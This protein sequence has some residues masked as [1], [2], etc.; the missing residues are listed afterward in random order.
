MR[1]I[2]NTLFFLLLIL[3]SA[4]ANM[5]AP[6]GGKKDTTEPKL[7]SS[8]PPNLSTNTKPK[9]IVLEFDEF[10]NLKDESNQ[11][12]LTPETGIKIDLKKKKKSLIVELQGELQDNTTYTLNFGDAI[13]DNNEGNVLRDFTYVFSTGSFMDSLNIKG[14][15]IDAFT[16][17]IQK[18]VVVGLYKNTD[19]S[20]VYKSKPDYSIR[21]NTEGN[22]R[23]KNVA[24]GT[25]K[26]I[27]LQEENNNKIYNQGEEKIAFEEN[28]IKLDSNLEKLELKLFKETPVERKILER[29]YQDDMAQ[30]IF[31]KS[32]KDL[33]INLDNKD[34][35]ISSVKILKNKTNDTI[36]FFTPSSIDTLLINISDGENYNQSVKLK[37]T[38]T[39]KVNSGIEIVVQTRAEK[40][41]N[42]HLIFDRP[43]EFNTNMDSVILLIDSVKFNI[44]DKIKKSADPYQYSIDLL[45]EAG[46]NYTLVIKDSS[47]YDM[48]SVY[49]L[50][51]ESRFRLMN[52]EDLGKLTIHVKPSKPAQYIVELLNETNVV[53]FKK[54]IN[55]TADV[56]VNNFIPGTYRLRLTE[57][58][59]KNNRWDTGNYLK[60]IQP[61]KIYYYPSKINLRANWE[62]EIEYSF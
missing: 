60:Q 35:L 53:K 49:T 58:D 38:R 23:I 43:M 9:K 8:S 14:T 47:F 25:Y 56:E 37:K 54:V 51:K 48:N 1:F 39:K 61:E 36:S 18:D 2:K 11:V 20:I 41:D 29:K 24:H 6:T 30:L 21:T 31:N 28:V 33:S 32:A 46:K 40:P 52:E 55:G 16:L 62:M 15:V 19:D 57:D 5:V 22:F 44:K 34:S 12:I 27:A 17:E 4:C 42:I 3:L 13:L 26:L 59:N 50:K 45:T 7:K 10:F